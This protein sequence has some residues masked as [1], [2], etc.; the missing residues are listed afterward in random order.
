VPCAQ[1]AQ[2]IARDCQGQHTT[3][4]GWSTGMGKNKAALD[5]GAL[6]KN[7]CSTATHA[8]GEFL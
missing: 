7:Y 1:V 8:T 2:T 4:S 5:P 6:L 3:Q